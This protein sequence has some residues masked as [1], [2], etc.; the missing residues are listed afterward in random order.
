MQRGIKLLFLF[1]LIGFSAC[2]GGKYTPLNENPALRIS[3]AYWQEIVPGQEDGI[4]Q[5]VLFFPI[6]ESAAG[7]AIDSVYFKGY[8]DALKL[9]E[10]KKNQGFRTTFSIVKDRAIIQPPY[11]IAE[12]EALISYTDENGKKRYFKVGNIVQAESIF[13][14]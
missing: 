9:Y 11:A 10:T 7:Y 5:I 1:G 3:E 12:N 6:A 8:H 4:R 2:S 14:P 13:M